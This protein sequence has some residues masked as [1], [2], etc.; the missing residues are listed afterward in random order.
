MLCGASCMIYRQQG[1]ITVVI[2]ETRGRCGLPPPGACEWAPTA[3]PVTSGVGKK[4]KKNIWHCNKAPPTVALTLLGTHPPFHPAAATA[5]C[6][7]WAVP[8]GLITNPSQDPVTRSS[9]CITSCM[10]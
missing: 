9:L 6:S 5:K 3:A 4:K 1:Q 2:S 10:G 8:R 7:L